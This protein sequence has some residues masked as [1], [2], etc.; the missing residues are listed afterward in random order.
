MADDL[1]PDRWAQ[2]LSVLSLDAAPELYTAMGVP[3]RDPATFQ[4]VLR[5]VIR[6]AR[7]QHDDTPNRVPP[8]A[9]MLAERLPAPDVAAFLRWARGAFLGYHADQPWWSAWDIVFT[10]W[11][12]SRQSDL[13]FL[14]PPKRDEL[15]AAYRRDAAVNDVRARGEKAAEQPLSDWD[16]EVFARRDY[17]SEWDSGPYRVIE[18]IARDH[19]LKTFVARTL[20]GLAPAE[21]EQL[22]ARAQAL[23]AAL[24][25]WMPGPLP[26]LDELLEEL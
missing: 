26:R 25:V 3:T 2:L 16:L 24:G 10:R 12:T 11:A 15:V 18:A 9:V 13:D 14:P 4:K 22:H 6:D 21:R 5:E 1:T 19:R 23:L 7:R 20:P 17:G 8:L